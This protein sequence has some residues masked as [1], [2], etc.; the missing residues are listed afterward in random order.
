MIEVYLKWLT[1]CLLL[2]TDSIHLD[3]YVHE[4][5][6][7][8]LKRIRDHWSSVTGFLPLQFDKI[9]FKKHKISTNRKNVT[10]NYYGL[11]RV[12]VNKSSSLNR[13][14]AGWIEGIYEQCGMV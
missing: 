13:K 3:I 11:L 14:I 10:E 5:H 7:D 8:N 9:Y 12:K 6:K 2:P 1:K 4:N